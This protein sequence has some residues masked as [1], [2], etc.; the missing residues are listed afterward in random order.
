M[1]SVSVPVFSMFI[2]SYDWLLGILTRNDKEQIV[3]R[4]KEGRIKETKFK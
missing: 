4:F 1:C 3:H 2:N